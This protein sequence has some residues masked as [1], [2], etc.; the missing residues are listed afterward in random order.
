MT[1]TI[2]R[3]DETS[4]MAHARSAEVMTSAT[5][6]LFAL[7]RFIISALSKSHVKK[8]IS[9]KKPTNTITPIKNSMISIDEW[10]KKSSSLTTLA[11]K[12]IVVPRNAKLSLKCQN[13]M[14]PKIEI[15]KAQRA[16]IWLALKLRLDPKNPM[17]KRIIA[18]TMPFLKMA[19]FDSILNHPSA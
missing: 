13:S 16:V 7:K 4:S 15:E 10:R 5:T 1:I 12:R 8:P 6:N 2:K 17:I 18:S 14:V 9:F 3:I 19:F 11:N